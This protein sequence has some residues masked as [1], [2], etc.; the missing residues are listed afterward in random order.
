M[1]E[2]HDQ[3]E[4]RDRRRRVKRVSDIRPER[5]SNGGF[6]EMGAGRPRDL[7]KSNRRKRL[8]IV[9]NGEDARR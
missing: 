5:A 3:I 9:D 2:P 7:L 4:T 1:E 8:R 6:E